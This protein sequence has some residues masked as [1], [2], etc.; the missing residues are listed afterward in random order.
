MAKLL[1][2]DIEMKPAIVH[3]WGLFNQT[4]G[5]NQVVE[6]PGM[7]S[8]AARWYGEKKVIFKSVHHD[9][10]ED[11]VKTL[12]DL[13]NEADAL[14]S[15]NGQGFDTKH[16]KREFLE[17]GLTPPSPVKEIDLMR[18]VKS[19][20]RMLSNKLD[21]V[22]QQLGVG[23]KKSTGGHELWVACMAGDEAAWR[24]MRTYN[25]QDVNLLIDLYER[26]LPWLPA[27]NHPN[28]AVLDGLDFACPRCGSKDLER[29]GTAIKSTG[30]YQRYQCKNCGHWP[31]AAQRLTTT[32]LRPA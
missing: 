9:G 25:I 28:I 6:Q 19:Q 21:Y 8:F 20:F 29:R 13:L 22:S 23:A 7:I 4:H 17:L 2:W 1:A 26:L 5:I 18:G 11:M 16:A 12:W 3:S 27:A 31:S 15:W 30:T 14:I 24:K 32:E 10:R